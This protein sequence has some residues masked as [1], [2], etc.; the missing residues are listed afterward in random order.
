MED[1]ERSDEVGK[2]PTHLRLGYG[3]QSHL[4]SMTK[5]QLREVCSPISRNCDQSLSIIA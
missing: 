2:S 5:A 4:V 3:T 1:G